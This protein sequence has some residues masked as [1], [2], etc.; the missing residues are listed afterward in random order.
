M[1]R[2]DGETTEGSPTEE[3]IVETT[4]QANDERKGSN[5][6]FLLLVI[7]IVILVVGIGSAFLIS[8]LL[9]SNPDL[10]SS[11]GSFV[12]HEWESFKES[13]DK[14]LHQAEEF[15]RRSIWEDRKA[16]VDNHNKKADRS[17]TMALNKASDWTADEVERR[18]LGYIDVDE[19][20]G[21]SFPDF[22]R[23]ARPDVLDYRLPTA[24]HPDGLVTEVKD[25][26]K[27]GS[28]WAFSTTG[29]I[30]GVWAQKHGKLLSLSEQQLVDCA[31]TSCSGGNLGHGY[32]SA[33]V[34]I[35]EEKDYPYEN[36]SA[37]CRIASS[38][39][40][41]RVT[42]H[43]SVAPNEQDLEK[44]LFQM[45]YPISIAVHANDEFRHYNAGVFNDPDCVKGKVN[46]AV[47]LV[48]YN[49]TGPDPYWIVKNSWGKDWGEDGY[50]RMK[51]GENTC[52]LAKRP[53]YPVL[54]IY[55]YLNQTY[56]ITSCV[57]SNMTCDGQNT[58]PRGEKYNGCVNVTV[59]GRKCQAWASTSPH[60][61]GFSTDQRLL[62][63]YCRNPDGWFG[64][65]CYTTDPE[66]RWERC[67][68]QTCGEGWLEARYTHM[69][70]LTET[71]TILDPYMSD[72]LLLISQKFL[73][74]PSQV[75]VDNNVTQCEEK[76]GRSV[77]ILELPMPDTKSV[78]KWDKNSNLNCTDFNHNA[79]LTS[80]IWNLDWCNEK[81]GNQTDSL[82][83][84]PQC[85]LNPSTQK[86]NGKNFWACILKHMN[87]TKAKGLLESRHE[88]LLISNGD[89]GKS[90][91]VTKLRTTT[92]VQL[93]HLSQ[94][95][96]EDEEIVTICEDQ[97]P[98]THTPTDME[99]PDWESL[100]SEIKIE[101]CIFVLYE[102]NKTASC[103][104]LRPHCD[105]VDNS[106][107][108]EEILSGSSTATLS[109]WNLRWC[110]RKISGNKCNLYTWPECCYHPIV[111]KNV[112]NTDHLW[113]C[114]GNYAPPK[115][116]CED[117][118]CCK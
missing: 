102:E 70:Y 54:D 64:P 5:K 33:K 35:M 19:G 14:E 48:G 30:E 37:D 97:G 106:G 69:Q 94:H 72:L 7:A 109:S 114:V 45:G 68:V 51:M 113:E 117:P 63:N 76:E 111:R 93:L 40:V 60:N 12:D 18:L 92:A 1:E 34:G 10:V 39:A 11:V 75:S 3:E 80:P 32:D 42:G 43:E 23:F 26:G 50:I 91:S 2:V 98:Q 82:K 20:E 9:K 79:T 85:C 21:N 112:A 118:D 25:Q 53:V 115:E 8:D 57:D 16:L 52:G 24:D 105:N 78:I 15:M 29:G 73:P 65:W 6:K 46:H 86:W 116:K 49:K 31:K 4:P 89:T 58:D 84:W 44:A 59:S 108:G 67:P 90:E 71:V 87:H 100:Q 22:F 56:N 107:T 83:L 104:D 96:P 110:R 77:Q 95:F 88:T 55:E 28:C 74:S 103:S 13:W 36:K 99:N 27:C 47:L 61:H 62:G 101:N 17:Y 38:Q 66:K 81:I 41:A